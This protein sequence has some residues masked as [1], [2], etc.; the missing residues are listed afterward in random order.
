MDFFTTTTLFSAGNGSNCRAEAGRRAAAAEPQG[1]DTA[2]RYR[3][4][5]L[6]PVRQ[7]QVA[8]AARIG[9]QSICRVQRHR[10][11][12][13]CQTI[14]S[15]ASAD[16]FRCGSFGPADQHGSP[17]QKPPP[18]PRHLLNWWISLIAGHWNA[19]CS[20]HL[21]RLPASTPFLVRFFSTVLNNKAGFTLLRSHS[22]T[23]FL[24][25]WHTG[26]HFLCC[27]T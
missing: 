15:R 2:A 6:H 16:E 19:M 3:G 24:H 1:S 10:S 27:Q 20:L 14:S 17:C 8:V 4:R 21:E 11:A 26:A 12:G 18:A 7:F 9:S 5:S 25:L 22:S 13:R 23:Y